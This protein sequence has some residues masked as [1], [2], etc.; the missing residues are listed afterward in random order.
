MLLVLE[1]I[2]CNGRMEEEEEKEW[3][4]GDDD[5]KLFVSYR[6]LGWVSFWVCY[7]YLTCMRFGL[8]GVNLSG[9]VCLLFLKIYIF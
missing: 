9:Y 3:R 7:L 8:G 5:D 2:F 6:P 4:Y 1:S